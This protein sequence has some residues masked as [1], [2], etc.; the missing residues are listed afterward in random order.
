MAD[1][2]DIH[3]HQQTLLPLGFISWLLLCMQRSDRV[4][5]VD[6]RCGFRIVNPSRHRCNEL[7]R[8]NRTFTSRV[9]HL[10]RHDQHHLKAAFLSHVIIS[11]FF[12]AKIFFKPR[13]QVNHEKP[14]AMQCCK[15]LCLAFFMELY[16]D[17]LA[18]FMGLYPV[19]LA[20]FII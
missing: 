19:N 17:T 15:I 10:L 1:I 16:L 8:F 5:L 4:V 13:N 18:F 9:T 3:K 14:L 12:L 20:L 6:S 11:R 7:R 2:S